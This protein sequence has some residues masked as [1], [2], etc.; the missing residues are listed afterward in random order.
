PLEL[1]VRTVAQPVELRHRAPKRAPVSQPI[2]PT[3]A[4]VTRCA[5]LEQPKPAL[6][7][8]AP[9]GRALHRNQSLV[10]RR[11]SLIRRSGHGE[12]S[13]G[14]PPVRLSASGRPTG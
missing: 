2:Q 8:R 12:H 3:P 11:A 4:E 10:T 14:S 7:V 6:A 1:L 5:R 13:V 9:R